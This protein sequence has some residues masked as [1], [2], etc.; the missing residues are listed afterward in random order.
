[1][2]AILKYSTDQTRPNYK[3]EFTSSKKRVKDAL[4]TEM[5]TTYEDPDFAQNWH[6]D[7][8]SVY[9]LPSGWRKPSAKFIRD[10]V[11]RL[12]GS[13]YSPNE[14][15]VMVSMIYKEGIAIKEI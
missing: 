8:V 4:N 15:G 13:M 1:M 5:K 9:E 12:L 14:S 6:H 2:Y 11:S 7:L 3:V 10:E